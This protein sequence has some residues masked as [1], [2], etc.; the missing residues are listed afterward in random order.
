MNKFLELVPLTPVTDVGSVITKIT[1]CLK[2]VVNPT[3][4]ENIDDSSYFKHPHW[5]LNLYGLSFDYCRE[6]SSLV[7]VDTGLTVTDLLTYST[8]LLHDLDRINERGYVN[9]RYL[10]DCEHFLNK[11]SNFLEGFGYE[12]PLLGGSKTSYTL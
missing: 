1:P 12:E 8:N 9:M 4:V 11:I 5:L 3:H 6:D 7:Y 2:P 10:D